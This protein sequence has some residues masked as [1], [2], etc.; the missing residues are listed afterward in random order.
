MPNLSSLSIRPAPD[1][2]NMMVRCL[3]P[4]LLLM[5]AISAQSLPEAAL[6]ESLPVVEPDSTPRAEPNTLVPSAAD[7]AVPTGS[8]ITAV[9]STPV[10]EDDDIDL[11]GHTVVLSVDDGYHSIFTNVYPL[12]KRYDMTITLGVICDY[13]REG[14]PSYR[15]AG[16]FM[17]RSEIQELIDSCGIEIASHTF[18]HPFLTRIDSAAAWKE[19]SNSRTF[20]ESIFDTEVVTFVYPYGD[21]NRRVRRMVRRAG[22]KLGRAVRPGSPNFGADPYR[23]PELELRKETKIEDIKA[24]IR[25]RRTTVL[26]LHQIVSKPDVF[27]QWSVADF[28]ELLGWMHRHNV[29]V[30]TLARLHREWWMDKMLQVMG[31]V[32]AAYPDRRKRLLFQDVDVDA[33]EA[34]HP[35]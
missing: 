2:M 14:K 4:V 6:P 31:D 30:A 15:P 20:L 18:S 25:R 32:A 12:L 33:T 23:I 21:M 13:V 17:K 28:T 3:L 5:A 26:L 22:Y 35:R 24:H 1:M 8:V 9:D 11:S 27:T 29:R 7:S 19:I 34:A 16:G 10:R